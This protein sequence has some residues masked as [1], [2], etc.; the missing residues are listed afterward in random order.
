M[1][2]IRTALLIE[3]VKGGLVAGDHEIHGALTWKDSDGKWQSARLTH[4]SDGV[5][6]RSLHDGIKE[7]HDIIKDKSLHPDISI[8]VIKKVKGGKSG[9]GPA[10]RF[11]RGDNYLPGNHYTVSKLNVAHHNGPSGDTDTGGKLHFSSSM[12]ETPAEHRRKGWASTLFDHAHKT[13]KQHGIHLTHDREGQLFDG[14]RWA[15]RQETARGKGFEPIHRLA[16]KS[17]LKALAIHTKVRDELPAPTQHHTKMI[18]L[19][20]KIL[21]RVGG[22]HG[23]REHTAF[24]RTSRKL[25][26]PHLG[27]RKVDKLMRSLGGEGEAYEAPKRRHPINFANPERRPWA[28][29]AQPRWERYRRRGIM[30]M[31]RRM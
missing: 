6:H 15:A 12:I 29:P 18:G 2:L 21:D 13:L 10:S 3:A 23:P 16:Q 1:D 4:N 25:G 17:A 22:Y 31:G 24:Q 28:R 27:R 30:D 11:T 19:A 9:W 7:Y 5:K 14:K 8:S 26:L 20:N